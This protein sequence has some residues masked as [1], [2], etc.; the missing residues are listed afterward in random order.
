M[1]VLVYRGIPFLWSLCQAIFIIMI[2]KIVIA[3]FISHPCVSPQ[4]TFGGIV[5][6]V[7][8]CF[9]LADLHSSGTDVTLLASMAKLKAGRLA[10][11][12]SDSCLQ[13]WGGMGFTNEVSFPR[14]RCSALCNVL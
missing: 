5:P 3:Y 14:L 6:T 8:Q 9:F 1:A 12:V 10:R 13:Y 2:I 11:E 7:I 4:L